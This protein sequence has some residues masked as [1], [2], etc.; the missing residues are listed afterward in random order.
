MSAKYSVPLSKVITA[1]SLETVYMPKEASEIL[2]TSFEVCRPSLILASHDHYFNSERV[3][4]MGKSEMEFLADMTDEERL[5]SL[6]RFFSKKPITVILPLNCV[7]CPEDILGLAQKYQV[8]L[9]KTC[10]ETSNAISS[11]V[12]Y[13]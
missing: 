11:L 1:E 9:L 7:D 5:S 3:Q 10:E 6:D 12:S 8:P 13:L 4:F 2:I